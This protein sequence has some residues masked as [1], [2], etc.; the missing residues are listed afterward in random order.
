MFATKGKFAE[1]LQSRRPFFALA[2]S[3]KVTVIQPWP[4]ATNLKSDPIEGSD[5]DGSET[6]KMELK[7]LQQLRNFNIP[8]IDVRRSSI[9][10]TLGDGEDEEDDDVVDAGKTAGRKRS[11]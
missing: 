2:K 1:H 3:S 10:D 6:P 7:K 5:G 4:S 9:D 8:S 11:Q